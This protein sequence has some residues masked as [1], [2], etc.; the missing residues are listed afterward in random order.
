[1]QAATSRLMPDV[2]L[3][4]TTQ[5]ISGTADTYGWRNLLAK[6]ASQASRLSVMQLSCVT[7]FFRQVSPTVCV[8]CGHAV[9]HACN[10]AQDCW[11][12][13]ICRGQGTCHCQV[14]SAI[15]FLSKED[16]STQGLL[17]ISQC[18]P[19]EAQWQVCCPQC[20]TIALSAC[21]THDTCRCQVIWSHQPDH[22]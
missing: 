20:L 21:R 1:M 18:L 13:T 7:S 10:G 2:I 19:I 8:C 5:I 4:C 14:T 9:S 17:P 15:S 12:G 3:V 6:D 11:C 16:G 22:H